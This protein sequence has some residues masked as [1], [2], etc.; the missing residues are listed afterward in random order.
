MPYFD[1]CFPEVNICSCVRFSLKHKKH[2]LQ[3]K[4]T[5]SC[6][7]ASEVLH[8][9]E[10]FLSNCIKLQI[11]HMGW[12]SKMLIYHQ[13]YERG[14]KSWSGAKRIFCILEKLRMTKKRVCPTVVINC[15]ISLTKTLAIQI[16][17]DSRYSMSLPFRVCDVI[18]QAA[19]NFLSVFCKIIYVFTS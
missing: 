5:G 7:Y 15:N 16:F 3:P 12:N 9:S 18:I 8:A 17:L 11:F 14:A 19:K 13:L 6:G 2:T 1:I 4:H 10:V